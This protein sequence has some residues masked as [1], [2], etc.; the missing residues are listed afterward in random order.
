MFIAPMSAMSEGGAAA[1]AWAM[2][3]W[4]IPDMAPWSIPAMAP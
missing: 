4:S 1:G 2:A 3:A